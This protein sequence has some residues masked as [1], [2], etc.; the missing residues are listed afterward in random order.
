MEI[1]EESEGIS[2]DEKSQD[3]NKPIEDVLPLT[4]SIAPIDSIKKESEEI[5]E[6]LQGLT[7]ETD[8]ENKKGLEPLPSQ[9]IEEAGYI[10]QD[11]PKI[12]EM[13]QDNKTPPSIWIKDIEKGAA[14]VEEG[15]QSEK[16][17]ESQIEE[18][19]SPQYYDVVFK[20]AHDALLSGDTPRSINSYKILIGKNKMIEKVINQLENDLVNFPNVNQLWILL[21]DAYHQLGEPEK[22][23]ES[24]HKAEKYL[25][26]K[27]YNEQ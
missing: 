25:S 7:N 14:T 18:L 5:P 10:D 4:E 21:G 23:L 1:P 17:N 15:T 3:L 6:W 12:T 19:I 22:A 24:Y 9:S 13:V 27:D 20:D 2:K 16:I 8:S 26:P 11:T